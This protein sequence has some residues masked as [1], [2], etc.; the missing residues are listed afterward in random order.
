MDVACYLVAGGIVVSDE[1][2]SV[3]GVV[4]GGAVDRAADDAV[5]TR[6]LPLGSPHRFRS[7]LCI[8]T[9]YPGHPHGHVLRIVVVGGAVHGEPRGFLSGTQ[10][11]GKLRKE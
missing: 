7:G 5:L 9:V 1:I 11:R 2:P 4:G 6:S 8:R 10:E 3:V